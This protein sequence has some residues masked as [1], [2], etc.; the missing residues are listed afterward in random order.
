MPLCMVLANEIEPID[1][2]IVEDIDDV[3]DVDD[4][5]AFSEV[6][7]TNIITA[8]P[9]LSL[10]L[11]D[12][13][14]LR[15]KE[16]GWGEIVIMASLASAA[17]KGMDDILDM[18]DQGL[19][20]G[21]ISKELGLEYNGLGQG[22]KG[23]LGNSDKKALDEAGMEELLSINFELSE[24]DIVELATTGFKKQELLMA[25][26]VAAYAG[27][28]TQLEAVLSLRQAEQSWEEIFEAL[29]IEPEDVG[30]M[31]NIMK[32]KD[33][34]EQ[35]RNTYKELKDQ[36]KELKKQEKEK[37]RAEKNEAKNNVEDED[38]NEN[39]GVGRGRGKK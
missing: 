29:D 36:E 28:S 21:E 31:E 26:T 33:L 27:E 19:G 12:I 38:D 35:V 6:F 30:E 9:D 16:L 8:F 20:L 4:D 7:A 18:R 3:D 13:Q 10:S 23:V 22:V 1:E 34:R 17:E 15:S 37:T 39:Q 2:E 11:E 24:S 25:F 14:E 32:N 5:S